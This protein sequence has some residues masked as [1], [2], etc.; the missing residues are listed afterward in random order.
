[1][2]LNFP[3]NPQDGDEYG[4]Y[5]YNASKNVWS[6]SATPPRYLVSQNV[7][8][9]ANNGDVWFN[10]S[11]A[12]SYIYYEDADS[13]QWVEI[14][15]AEGAVGTPSSLADI[16]GIDL[17]GLADGKTLVYDAANSE[18]I[19]GEAGGKFTVSDTAPSEAENGDT[20]FKSDDGKTYIYYVDT[21]GG[22]WV[23]I[24]SNTTGYLDIGQLNDV[25][26]VSPTT[27]QA[28]TYDGSGWVNATPASTLGSLTDVSDSTPADGQALVYNDSSGEWEPGAAAPSGV[29]VAGSDNIA[30]DFSDNVPLEKRTVTGD[31]VFTASNYSAGAN[32]TIY[33]QGDSV[34]RSLSFPQNWSFIGDIPIAIGANNKN[35]L[36]IKCFGTTESDVL[37]V[38]NGPSAFEPIVASGGSEQEVIIGGITYKVHTF[39]T[40]ENLVVTN[41][42]S[43]AS[44]DYFIVAGGGA[45]GPHVGGGGGAG[46]L[47]QGTFQNI[48]ATTYTAVVGGG[49]AGTASTGSFTLGGSN[50]SIFG[51]TALGGGGGGGYGGDG[52]TFRPGQQG[53]SGGGAGGGHDA[54]SAAGGAGTA[55]QGFRGGNT[56]SRTSSN[57][58][59]AGGGGAAQA[60]SD[61]PSSGDA[62]RFDGAPGLSNS[63]LGQGNLFF[64][65][66]GGSGTY[67]GVPGGYGGAGGGGG[68]GSN[69]GTGGL[70]DTSSINAAN[71]G[72]TG[73]ERP[74]GGAGALNSGGGGGGAGG[75]GGPAT[76]GASGGSGI[77]IVRYPITDPN[78]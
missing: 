40:T 35:S 29:N 46:G 11:T 34:R 53:G 44:A 62:G 67:T 15:G 52:E 36:D 61:R 41:P 27:G 21:D 24:A 48:N 77:I 45:G 28:L 10:T 63:W 66:G 32:K 78:I 4:K 65:G 76:N 30:L 54:A 64:A 71:N 33:L 70:G 5:V 72:S 59:G 17:T 43:L 18:W 6:S 23:E 13:S 68:G 9:T 55:G 50:S 19:P 7:P 14:G 38:W 22:Q 75:G 26:I 74:A 1:M 69:E 31:V 12:R 2:A 37:A 73:A 47:L 16:P 60:A 58:S 51:Q 56:G 57:T 8:S 49:G 20:W 3:A 39:T 25:T 42:G